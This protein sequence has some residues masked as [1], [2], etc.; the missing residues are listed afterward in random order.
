MRNPVSMGRSTSRWQLPNIVGLAGAVSGLLAGVVMVLLSPIL[1][2]LTGIGIWDPVKL[3]AATWYGPSV[4]ETPGFVLE[5]VL[6]GTAIHFVT[7]LVLGFIFGLVFNRLFHLPTDYGM[8]LL[9]GMVYGILIFFLAYML[10]LPVLNPA[11]R[12][13]Y[14]APFLAQNMVFGICVGVFFIFLRPRPYE[15]K[16]RLPNR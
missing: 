4:V 5:P 13:F 16:R 12:D 8:P 6:I 9:V 7:S 3:I 10:V 2:L 1:S 14:I 11:L 15:E